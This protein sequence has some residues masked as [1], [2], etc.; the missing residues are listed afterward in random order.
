MPAAV[1]LGR[2]ELQLGRPAAA[3]A[4]FEKALATGDVAAA[5]E[6]LGKVAHLAGDAEAAIRHLERALELDPAATGAHYSLA[7]AYRDQRQLDQAAAHL[8]RAGDVA[9][10][11]PDP[12]IQPLGS[13]AESPQFYL[14]QGAE[15]LGN[16]DYPSARHRFHVRPRARHLEL[17]RP[18]RPGDQ[19]RSPGRP[20]W[21]PSGV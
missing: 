9:A 16:G 14:V 20:R 18:P 3:R 1:R 15:A 19:P 5:H 10:R 21:R 12:L 8:E 7:Q 13:L 4:A 11:L 17:P 6:G 2:A